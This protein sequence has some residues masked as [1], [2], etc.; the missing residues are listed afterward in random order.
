[1][2]TLR[3][4]RRFTRRGLL[5]L[6]LLAGSALFAAPFFWLVSTSA[7]APEEL[8][9]PRWKIPVPENVLE[10]PWM[11]L[12]DNERPLRPLKVSAADWRRQ[13]PAIRAELTARLHALQAE[14]PEFM[15]PHLGHPDWSEG[16]FVRLLRRAPDDF[17]RKSEAECAAWFAENTT[18][19]LARDVF[20]QVYR[21]FALAD[22]NFIGWDMSIEPS[23][24]P[25]EIPWR[26]VDGDASIV[27]R[28]E[29]LLRPAQ[30]LHYSFAAT[31]HFSVQAV[32]PLQMPLENLKR[33]RVSNHADLSWHRL[34]ADLEFSGRKYRSV[35][36]AYLQN[37]RWQDSAWQFASREDT[38]VMVKSWLIMKD[39]GPSGFDQPGQVRLTL[40][41]NK[42]GPVMTT[43]GKWSYNY[44]EVMRQVPL[45]RYVRN[46]LWLVLLNIAGQ[47]LGSSMVAFAFARLRWPGREFCFILVLATLMVPPQ[48]TLVPVFLI[49][50]QLG[51]YNTLKPLWVPAFFG[52]AFYIFLLRQ[53]MKSIP[54]DLE[55][56]AKIDGCSYWGIYCRII[57]PL[58]KP[59]LATTAI[60]TFMSVWNDF[61]G[62]LIFITRQDLYPLSLGLFS[63]H[64]V[65]ILMAKYELMMAASVLMTVPVILLF[66]AAQRHF[67][68][69]ITLT[70][71]KG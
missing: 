65:Y 48:V 22:I 5:H 46:S 11:G 26:V 43:L 30:E 38:D 21:R 13:A 61:M 29:G 4:I 16:L 44:R 20:D 59:A 12:R 32:L 7:K 6:A 51:W 8:Y 69:G 3:H 68:Q 18:P 41:L 25:I 55:D 17:F 67:I 66:F 49:F 24:P 19:E 33:V 42:S 62:P 56:S 60:F 63:L 47:I 53:F 54:T 57:L 37:N 34:W 70:G 35:E 14:L 31:D 28:P 10:S 58:I 36:A 1:M 71:L 52:S 2:T 39:D 45:W 15:R 64:A 40:H 50:K 9:P 23:R 27:P